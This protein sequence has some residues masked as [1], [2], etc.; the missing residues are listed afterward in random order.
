MMNN[1]HDLTKGSSF[2]A[3]IAF[4]IP[5]FFSNLFQ[6]LYNSVDSLI[7]GNVLGKNALAAVSSSGNILFFFNSFFIGTTMGAGVLVSKTFGSKEY[8]K[9]R[10]AIHTD[11]ALGII[12]GIILTIIG[13]FLAPVILKIMK[14]D[15]EVLPNSIMYFQCYFLGAIGFVMYNVFNG[16]LNALG[17]SK[18]SLI[19]LIISSCL[20]IILDIIFVVV[21]KFGVGSAAVATAISQ[22]TS[23]ILAFLFLIRKGTVYQV[24]VNEIKLDKENL[25]LILKYG[26]PSG[27]QNSVISLS[28][29]FI[30][31]N[32]NTFGNDA[33][34]GCGTYSKIEGF[35]F[36]PVNCFTM[37]L[38][39]FVSQNL[40]AKEYNR[41]KK[42]SRFG[43]LVGVIL[44]E[45]VGAL[46]FLFMPYIARLFSDDPEVIRYASLQAKV[47]CLFYFLM[48]FSHCVAAILR[49]AGKAFV[50]ML[51]MLSVWCI[52]R[53]IYVYFALKL[54][55]NIETLFTAYPVTWTISSIIY[56]IYYNFTKWEYSFEKQ[57]KKLA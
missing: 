22:V 4:A 50:P 26:L 46:M 27:I 14:T 49:G 19:Y 6:Q 3:I 38:S 33:M 41:A 43:I 9:M 16:I 1:T 15:A 52:F 25:K 35:A 34:A 7:V 30:Q 17:N 8:S 45:F 40:G 28:N 37:A 44:A 57:D 24:K 2:K 21:F 23:A 20:N 11:I 48:A 10:K 55:P 47:D 42:G 31:S 32:I 51:I 13:Y 36:L 54:Y 12:M 5:L 18:R 56:F 29:M 39:T 53:V